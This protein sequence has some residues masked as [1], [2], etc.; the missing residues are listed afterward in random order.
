LKDNLNLS[1]Y[2]V[3]LLE[4]QHCSSANFDSVSLI[5]FQ[6]RGWH[7]FENVREAKYFK[8]RGYDL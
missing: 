2:T 6:I 8:E 3:L 1:V 5:F 7:H 4:E